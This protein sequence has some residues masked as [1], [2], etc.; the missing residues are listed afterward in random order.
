MVTME[1]YVFERSERIGGHPALDF[2]N[3]VERWQ[4]GRPGTEYLVDYAA[5]ARWHAVTGLLDTR[6]LKLL[7]AGSPAARR[8]AWR[9]A[10][11]LRDS[12]YQLFA[13][14]A[15]GRPAPQEELDRLQRV[16]LQTVR[17]RRLQADGRDVVSRWNFT[18]APPVA[19][20]GPVAWSAGELLVRGP[21]D[22]IKACPPT[23]GC[24]WLF[25]DMSKNRSRSWCS[26]KSC[27]N[28]AKVRRFRARH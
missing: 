23:D 17:W 18:G 5:L 10:V 22:R 24:G 27:G 6:A 11:I 13:T 8:K 9:Q 7:D 15:S 19:I 1:K 2:V 12:L 16:L 20:L 26:M 28:A 14:L 3:T 25:L 4:G 21:L